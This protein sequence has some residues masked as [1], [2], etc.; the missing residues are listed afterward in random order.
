MREVN[1]FLRQ[2][3]IFAKGGPE[4]GSI[5]IGHLPQAAIKGAGGTYYLSKGRPLMQNILL[6]I[7]LILALALIALILLQRSEGGGLGI[8]GGAGGTSARP[9]ATPLTKLTWALASGFLFTSLALTVLAVSSSG[10]RSVIDGV[11]IEEPSANGVVLPPALEG[12]LLP[13]SSSDAPA[14]PPAPVE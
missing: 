1:G 2:L 14:I 10:G 12:G 3:I 4:I 9:P 5:A 8:G 7:H 13:P 11:T 6:I